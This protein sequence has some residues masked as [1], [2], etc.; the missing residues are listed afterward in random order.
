MPHAFTRGV[1]NAASHVSRAVVTSSAARKFLF[2]AISSRPTAS[3]TELM[4]ASGLC[5]VGLIEG[6]RDPDRHRFSEMT[7]TAGRPQRVIGFPTHALCDYQLHMSLSQAGGGH[8]AH[9]G[10]PQAVIEPVTACALP[11]RCKRRCCQRPTTS[12]CPPCGRPDNSAQ[13][14]IRTAANDPSS[15]RT[16]Y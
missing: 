9:E 5:T 16:V 6:R 2:L 13:S 3:D 14:A 8:P 4:H 10:V 12:R 11:M 1:I 7:G 15:Q